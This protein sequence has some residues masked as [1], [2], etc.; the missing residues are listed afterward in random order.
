MKQKSQA[1]SVV[2][3]KLLTHD[4]AQGGA[5]GEAA[6]KDG[7][8]NISGARGVTRRVVLFSLALAVLFGYCI[9]V[10]DYKFSNTFL[11]A[12]HLPAAAVVVLL[13]CLLILN[14]LLH[15]V[16]GRAA[17]ANLLLFGALG[18]ALLSGL[19]YQFNDKLSEF[20]A[21]HYRLIVWILLAVALASGAAY[22]TQK[23]RLFLLLTPLFLFKAFVTHFLTGVPQWSSTIVLACYILGVAAALLLTGFLLRRPLARNEILTVYIT[24]LFS[25]LVPGRGG[26]NFFI[27]NILAPFYF[28]TPENKWL[29]FLEKYIPSWMTPAL[30][31]SG[32]YADHKSIIEPWYTT[33]TAGQSIPWGAWFVPLLAWCSLILA[34]YCM[35]GCLGVMLRAQWAEREALAFPL[36]RLPLEMTEGVDDNGQRGLVEFFHN[37][38]MWLG[39][40]IAVFIELMNGLHLYF[41]EVPEV[42]LQLPAGP[43]LSEPPWNQ[44]GG[45]S[46]RV[47]PAIV[48][49]TYLLT[50]EVSFSLWFIYL[51]TKVQLIIAYML[52]FPPNSMPTP[53]WTRGWAQGF[54]G[55]QQVGAYFAYVAFLLWLAR[56]H[57]AHIFRRV[58]GLEPPT[59]ARSRRSDV[60]SGGVL[61]F[62]LIV[63]LCGGLDSIFGHRIY[64]FADAMA[65]LFSGSDGPD[66]HRGRRRPDVCAYRLDDAWAALAPFQRRAGQSNQRCQRRA[67]FD[68]Q[69]Q[70]YV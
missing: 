8:E 26:E 50:S 22:Y 62:C 19:L 36:L 4:L 70:H 67:R 53:F 64:R 5:E 25:A 33:L 31:G 13:A 14:P 66:T 41:P 38:L 61:G 27:P 58:R 43:L 34:L 51:F 29:D 54:I 9:P 7:A 39:F 15:S 30:Y 2:S 46:L 6:F 28:A 63:C 57:F 24:C 3:S 69:R 21:P 35:L 32:R 10:V 56:H 16:A 48:G 44:I 47:F 37:P 20:L 60:V 52:G 55:Y 11:G 65:D 18:C 49:I 45:V 59:P 23:R 17:R 68:G 1:G 42:P 40:G 12:A